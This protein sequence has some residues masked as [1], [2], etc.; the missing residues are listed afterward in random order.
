MPSVPAGASKAKT[1]WVELPIEM[2]GTVI[3]ELF[4]TP[5]SVSSAPSNGFWVGS[6]RIVREPF[7]S[8]TIRI[9][10]LVSRATA[11]HSLNGAEGFAAKTGDTR[12]VSTDAT[13]PTSTAVAGI[14]ARRASRERTRI[15]ALVLGIV[16]DDLPVRGESTGSVYVESAGCSKLMSVHPQGPLGRPARSATHGRKGTCLIAAREGRSVR[17]GRSGASPRLPRA[18]SRLVHS[19]TDREADLAA[20]RTVAGEARAEGCC[21]GR[22]L[23]V[24]LDHVVPQRLAA[25]QHH[26]RR[27]H[28][29]SA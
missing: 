11:G 5:R 23:P 22:G 21:P 29:R 8:M 15:R 10:Q 28:L 2:D 3:P 12:A 4:W 1:A 26:V 27:Q 17:A 20:A 13:T 6:L 14:A 24:A 18:A 19:A 7:G 9:A 16:N 25:H